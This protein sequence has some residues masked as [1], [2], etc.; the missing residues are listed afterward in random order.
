MSASRLLLP[1]LILP[2]TVAVAV[3]A[4]LLWLTGGPSGGPSS[5]AVVAGLLLGLIGL[6][7]A[8]WT[9]RLFLTRGRG[10]PAPWDPPLDLV[11]EGPY[12]HVRNPMISSV[13]MI[14]AAEALLFQSLPIGLWLL[15]F[16]VGNMIYFPLVEEAGLER[17]FGEPYRAYKANVPRWIPRLQPWRP[18]QPPNGEADTTA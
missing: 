5:V 1:I 15:A 7:L 14:L 18:S 12:A 16:W 13:L 2:G 3:P 10:T 6:G 17:R 4:L 9:V 11:V 8:V